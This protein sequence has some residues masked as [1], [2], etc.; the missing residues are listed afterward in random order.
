MN[1]GAAAAPV[2]VNAEQLVTQ[3]TVSFYD[4]AP[5][6][7][8]IFEPLAGPEEGLYRFQQS[9]GWNRAVALNANLGDCEAKRL[10]DAGGG[11]GF[12]A[13]T[14]AWPAKPRPAA[15]TP[16]NNRV[17]CIWAL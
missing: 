10:D 12:D 16:A 4:G 15:I 5:R 2:V 6:A 14:C 13:G 1:P 9:L 11:D 3:S 17:S 8:Q 7:I